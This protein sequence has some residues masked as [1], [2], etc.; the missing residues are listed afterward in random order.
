MSS[1]AGQQFSATCRGSGQVYSAECDDARCGLHRA[2]I[3]FVD[4]LLEAGIADAEGN[5]GVTRPEQLFRLGA[6][7]CILVCVRR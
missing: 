1:L 3:P 7:A 4:P 6:F 5:R 2:K